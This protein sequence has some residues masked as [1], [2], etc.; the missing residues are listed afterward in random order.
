MHATCERDEILVMLYDGLVRQG[1]V[2][3]AKHIGL[4]TQISIS[5]VYTPNRV[6]EKANDFAIALAKSYN[7]YC[8]EFGEDADDIFVDVMCKSQ[9]KY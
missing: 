9:F 4:V 7:F 8:Q 2:Q 5:D 6:K 3:F 1:L